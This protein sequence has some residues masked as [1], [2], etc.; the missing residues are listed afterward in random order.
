MTQQEFFEQVLVALERL[1][2]PYM[3]TGSIGAMLYGEPRMTNDMDVV[4][5]PKPFHAALLARLFASE[6]HYIPPVEVIVDEIQR[7]GQFNIL[8]VGTGSKVD[9]IIRKQTD[10]AETEFARRQSV[11]FSA[12]LD[13]ASATPEDIIISKLTYY[14]M[15]PSSKHIDDI[16]GILAVSGNDLDHNYLRE[17][18]QRLGLTNA[19]QR[20]QSGPDSGATP[21]G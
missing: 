8:H 10:F 21:L 9:L 17:W 12:D 13:S 20:V 7:R 14:Q 4:I 15:S 3:V 5:D 19:W 11:P 16:R 1:D 18:V 6:D 2:V